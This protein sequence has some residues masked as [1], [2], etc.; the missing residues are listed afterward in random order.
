MK[1]KK[2]DNYE[3]IKDNMEI[4]LTQRTP[5]FQNCR[6]IADELYSISQYADAYFFYCAAETRCANDR[7]KYYCLCMMSLCF[8]MLGGRW[9]Y[10]SM[11]S[12][13]AMA[14]EP[15]CRESYGIMCENLMVDER[16]EGTFEKYILSRI[17]EGATDDIRDI[18][19]RNYLERFRGS[20]FFRTLE[21]LCRP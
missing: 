10:V 1:Y 17:G 18:D 8:M 20:R 3:S 5:S 4:Y 15:A 9:R 14:L 19:A 6:D 2:P 12:S 11:L 21:E 13:Y 7:Q 16:N